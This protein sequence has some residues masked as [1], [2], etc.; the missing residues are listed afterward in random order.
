MGAH[1]FPVSTIFVRQDI[2]RIPC[3]NLRFVS[4]TDDMC[5]H[6]PIYRK[7]RGS[8]DPVDLVIELVKYRFR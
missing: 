8:D 1:V 3:V 2:P 7:T 4:R 5:V 6:L